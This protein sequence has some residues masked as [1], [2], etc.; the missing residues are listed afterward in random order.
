M[1]LFS[2]H[3]CSH[4]HQ[5]FKTTL[6]Q[7]RSWWFSASTMRFMRIWLQCADFSSFLLLLIL[8][9]TQCKICGLMFLFIYSYDCFVLF[10]ANLIL[11]CDPKLHLHSSITMIYTSNMVNSLFK[12]ICWIIHITLSWFVNKKKEK[13]SIKL[14]TDLYHLVTDN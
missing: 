14:L 3:I 12:T 2:L 4:T 13:K 9:L 1:S 7:N 6:N 10:C 8:V 11:A 5:T